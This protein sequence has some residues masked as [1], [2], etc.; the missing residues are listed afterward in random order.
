MVRKIGKRASN[1]RNLTS[2]SSYDP[3]KLSDH[4]QTLRTWTT[5]EL[6][7]LRTFQDHP[8]SFSRI[9]LDFVLSPLSFPVQAGVKYK[10]ETS[11]ILDFAFKIHLTVVGSPSNSQD[12]DYPRVTSIANVSGP[13]DKF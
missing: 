9:F 5:H 3:S 11:K 2:R 12:L 1:F 6:H 4:P 13:S 10:H 8:T 7:R